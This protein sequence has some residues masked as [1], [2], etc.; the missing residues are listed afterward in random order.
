MNSQ[1]LYAQYLVG[2]PYTPA[3]TITHPEHFDYVPKPDAAM[4]QVRGI[5]V[6]LVP[7]MRSVAVCAGAAARRA[8]YVPETNLRSSWR[9]PGSAIEAVS[10]TWR[11]TL[12]NHH[13]SWHAAQLMAMSNQ[14]HSTCSDSGQRQQKCNARQER[15]S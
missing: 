13:I 8:P 4:E 7:L 11:Y 10:L 12:L 14:R 2:K 1:A 5:R 15:P 3:T 6:P 9:S